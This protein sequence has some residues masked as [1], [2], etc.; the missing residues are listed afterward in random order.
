[1]KIVKIAI[2]AIV[3]AGALFFIYMKIGKK[4]VE[5]P[6]TPPEDQARAKLEQT[7]QAM[8]PNVDPDHRKRLEEF[9]NK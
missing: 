6:V 9:M 1:M 4:N 5:V 2:V 7:V 8:S 3:I